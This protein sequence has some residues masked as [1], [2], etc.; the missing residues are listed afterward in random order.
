MVAS[1][2]ALANPLVEGLESG[3]RMKDAAGDFAI[4]NEDASVKTVVNSVSGLEHWAELANRG[5][6]AYEFWFLAFGAVSTFSYYRHFAIIESA[7]DD[8]HWI[9]SCRKAGVW[10]L[11]G[12]ADFLAIDEK[13]ADNVVGLG[14]GSFDS[15]I[16]NVTFDK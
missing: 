14:M 16:H 7:L 3:A 9:T 15:D 4:A 2:D 6:N 1:L 11:K 10:I 13:L 12:V 8:G 5:V